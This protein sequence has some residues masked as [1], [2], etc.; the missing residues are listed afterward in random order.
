MNLYSNFIDSNMS[1][2]LIAAVAMNGVIGNSDTN[3]I[4]WHLSGDF[5]HFKTTTSGQTIVMGSRTYQSI[6]GPLKNRRNV[7][8]SRTTVFDGADA[9]YP[10][11]S[12]ALR[13][14]EEG[15]WVIGG[16]QLY[17]EA[18]AHGPD[19]LYITIVDIEVDGD[20]KFPIV[21][22]A[23]K[24]DFITYEYMLERYDTY[25]CVKR[26]DWIEEN[27]IKYQICEFVRTN[28]T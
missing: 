6:P 27:G 19:L 28:R 21:G 13:G 18:L 25:N 24:D 14:E 20:V 9:T 7:V 4:P 12:D 17:A 22:S 2:N 16:A 8:V 10:V 15:F 1:F 5:K 23:F 3:S 11:F 26:S